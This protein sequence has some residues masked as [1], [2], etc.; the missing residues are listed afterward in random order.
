MLSSNVY[1]QKDL[2]TRTAALE[3]HNMWHIKHAFHMHKQILNMV[4]LNSGGRGQWTGRARDG[5]TE[6]L[7]TESVQFNLARWHRERD[8]AT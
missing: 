7:I 1:F 3:K 6:G 8:L 5:Q 2:Q 4:T